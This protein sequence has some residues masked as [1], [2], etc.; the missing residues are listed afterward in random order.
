[1]WPGWPRATR[2]SPSPRRGGCPR[3]AGWCAVHSWGFL[4]G[5]RQV[6]C[7]GKGKPEGGAAPGLGVGLDAPS[8]ADQYPAHAGQADAGTG[9]LA[10]RVQALEHAEQLAR[11]LH[12]EAGAVVAHLELVRPVGALA[13]LDLDPR[14]LAAAA[15]LDRVAEQVQPHLAQHVLV[16]H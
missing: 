3:P 2:R 8:M 15:V 6:A 9:E 16:A 1:G 4:G 12:V 5:C 7:R 14:R 13:V 10:G 11:V